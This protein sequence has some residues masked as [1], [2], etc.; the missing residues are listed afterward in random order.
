MGKTSK[1]N[2]GRS[3]ANPKVKAP[4]KPKASVGKSWGAKTFYKKPTVSPTANIRHKA[5]TYVLQNNVTKEKY[6]GRSGD[7]AKRVAQ[8]NTGRGAKWTNTPVG[9]WNVVKTY[10]GNNNTTENAITKGVMRNEGIASVRGG[11]YCQ[12]HFPAAQFRAI[13]KANGFTNY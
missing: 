1:K 8:H 5:G 7:I 12:E 13:K 6:I 2:R 3:F 9:Q 4:A 10:A 11:S